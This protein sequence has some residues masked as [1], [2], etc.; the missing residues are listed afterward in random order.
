MAGRAGKLYR[1]ITPAEIAMEEAVAKLGVPYRIQFPYYLWGVRFFPDFLLPTLKLIIEVDDD[2]HNEK[3]KKIADQQRTEELNALG[4]TV[5]RCTNREALDDAQGTLNRLLRE[6]QRT[7]KPICSL[8]QGLPQ[9]VFPAKTRGQKRQVR[10]AQRNQTPSVPP[11]KSS[12]PRALKK[13]ILTMEL[14]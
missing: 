7:N 13:V 1:D 10:L 11:P 8:A 12:T 3:A 6:C 14:N 9:R 5:V 2:S 4:W